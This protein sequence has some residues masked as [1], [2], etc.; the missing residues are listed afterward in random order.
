VANGGERKWEFSLK[1][2]PTPRG[3]PMPEP[4]PIAQV[5]F[6]PCAPS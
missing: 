1:P 2:D 3:I 4:M 6:C 5:P